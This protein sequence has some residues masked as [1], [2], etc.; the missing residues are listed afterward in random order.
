VPCFDHGGRFPPIFSTL[1]AFHSSNTSVYVC[2]YEYFVDESMIQQNHL[3]VSQTH[4][5]S[6]GKGVDCM[7][8]NKVEKNIEE[9]R[10]L[11]FLLEFHPFSESFFFVEKDE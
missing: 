7:L 6:F 3:W 11:L 4:I 2:V 1:V 8:S 5:L 9:E 10:G